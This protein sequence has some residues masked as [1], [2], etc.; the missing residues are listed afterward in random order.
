[1]GMSGF[2]RDPTMSWEDLNK[3][4]L[5]DPQNLIVS[6]Q[7]A[8][9]LSEKLAEIANYMIEVSQLEP[10]IKEEVDRLKTDID[11]L[12]RE[13]DLEFE[14]DFTEMYLSIPDSHKKNLTLQQG[15]VRIFFKDKYQEFEDNLREMKIMLVKKNRKYNEIDRRLRAAARILDVGRSILSALK[16]EIKSI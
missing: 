3:F 4:Q 12:Q 8:L 2:C 6:A 1:M 9:G 14:K 5:P 13:R 11:L 15:Y 10:E 16:E 7:S